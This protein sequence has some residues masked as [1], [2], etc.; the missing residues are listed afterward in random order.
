MLPRTFSRPEG[1][2]P[3]RKAFYLAME[4]KVTEHLYFGIF[5][6]EKKFPNREILLR[7]IRVGSHSSPLGVLEKL[8]GFLERECP[9]PPFEAWL[10]IDKD[11]WNEE[12]LAHLSEW[13]SEDSDTRFLALSNPKFEYWLLLHF[14]EGND[15]VSSSKCS[16]RLAKYPCG[17]D[18]RGKSFDISKITREMIEKAVARAKKR[19]RNT[20]EYWP[21]TIG[22]TTVYKLVEKI[23]KSSKKKQ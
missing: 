13:T 9:D 7:T 3:F 22:N 21:R 1:K 17:Y 4:G 10:V 16:D 19:N 11:N 12:Q 20:H 6:D 8:R 14:E 18:K 5:N 15:I 23:L 2:R